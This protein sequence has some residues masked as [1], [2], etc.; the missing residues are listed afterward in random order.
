MPAL[1]AGFV[2]KE[3]AE[4]AQPTDRMDVR[5]AY[6]DTALYVGARMY[7]GAPIQAP[8][9]RRDEGEQA[10]HLLVS[11]DT[12]LDRRTASTF[13]VTAAGVRLDH[14]YASDADW[15]SDDGFDP[16]WQARTCVDEQGW[17]AELWIPFSQLRFTDRRSAG[18]GTEHPALGAVAQRGSD[19]VLDAANRGAAGRRC[20]ATCTASTASTRAVVSR[21]CRTSRARRN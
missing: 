2:Q 4:G 3:P 15:T 5:F 6:D 13:G 14:Y 16:V 10:E 18:L 19:W 8:M 11:L 12:Y 7:S 1:I 20:S 9:G 21:S 17:T